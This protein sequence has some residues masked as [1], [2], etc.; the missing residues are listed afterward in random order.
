MSVSNNSLDP[1]MEISQMPWKNFLQEIGT[2]QG[3]LIQK[4]SNEFYRLKMPAEPKTFSYI[5]VASSFTKKTI[6]IEV[7]PF[8]EHSGSPWNLKWNISTRSHTM[9][10]I[11]I[12]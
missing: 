11:S 4:F 7:D 1:E 10:V 12:A 2:T 6:S 9:D 5:N 8:L 3:N